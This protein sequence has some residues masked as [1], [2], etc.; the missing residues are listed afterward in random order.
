MLCVHDRKFLG[1][2]EMGEV[3]R[4]AMKQM[5]LPAAVVEHPLTTPL[6]DKLSKVRC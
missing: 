6:V 1:M 5:P 4:E 3:I 2:R